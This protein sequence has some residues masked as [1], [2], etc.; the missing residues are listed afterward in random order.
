ME[1]FR[2]YMLTISA[3]FAVTAIVMQLSD[4]EQGRLNSTNTYVLSNVW[5][6]DLLYDRF[7]AHKWSTW[8][9]S[10]G[11][12][13]PVF[14]DHFP[15]LFDVYSES[16]SLNPQ[17]KVLSYKIANWPSFMSYLTQGLDLQE[18]SLSMIGGPPDI[19]FEFWRLK[20]LAVPNVVPHRYKLKLTEEIS[21]LIRFRFAWGWGQNKIGELKK[22][23][24]KLT[25][26]IRLRVFALQGRNWGGLLESC[27]GNQTILLNV[28]KFI[29]NRHWR[30]S[31]LEIGQLGVCD[32]FRKVESY[33][34]CFFKCLLV[35]WLQFSQYKKWSGWDFNR[36]Y[37]QFGHWTD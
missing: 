18:V 21:E 3:K 36:Y 17:T 5:S 19:D 30:F 20:I 37:S 10:A 23:V 15:V 13:G 24:N 25:K 14:S 28:T 16:L 27:W 6:K 11:G 33:C 34:K 12:F 26:D 1:I 4:L 35:P 7:G 8:Y 31:A 2:I 29:N 9:F 22:F 32:E